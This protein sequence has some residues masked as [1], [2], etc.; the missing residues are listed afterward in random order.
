[1]L[2]PFA[3]VVFGLD[4]G[5]TTK[6]TG[7]QHGGVLAGMVF[8]GIAGGGLFGAK[9]GSFRTWTIAGCLGSAVALAGLAAGGEIGPGFPIHAAVFVLGVANGAFAVAAIGAMM[10][11][12]AEGK[13]RREGMR[14]GLFGAAQ[15]VAFAMGDLLGPVSSD[16]AHLAFS[17]PATAYAAVFLLQVCLFIAAAAL[18][19][20]VFPRE[21]AG[22]RITITADTTNTNGTL[23]AAAA[24]SANHGGR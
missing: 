8:V 3:G 10:G 9:L 7:L 2:E 19:S 12:A 20:R 21:Q 6:L 24:G 1:M 11:I 14:M 16:L 5:A 13:N 22:P 4:P 23:A 18:A 17:T 15:A